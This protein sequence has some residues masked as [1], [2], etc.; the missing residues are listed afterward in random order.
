MSWVNPEGL[1]KRPQ[2]ARDHDG[3]QPAHLDIADATLATLGFY[4]TSSGLYP[5]WYHKDHTGRILQYAC[6]THPGLWTARVG[7]E[8]RNFSTPEAAA[9]WLKLELSNDD[10]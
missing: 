9:I 5:D 7:Y 3:P 1:P 2:R 4:R 10:S 8:E 6:H